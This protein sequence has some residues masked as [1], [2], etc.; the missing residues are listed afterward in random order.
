MTG[1]LNRRNFTL[2]E[3]L[4]TIAIIAILAAV[5]LPALN[6]ARAKR[7]AIR[8]TSNLKQMGTLVFLYAEANDGYGIPFQDSP[9]G[10]GFCVWPDFLMPY[11]KPG[12]EMKAGGYRIYVDSGTGKYIPRDIF[13]CP[14]VGNPVVDGRKE[15]IKH[16]GMNKY[17]SLTEPWQLPSR[18]ILHTK[19]PAA[20]SYIADVF[21]PE[22]YTSSGGRCFRYENV[23]E[24]PFLH[25]SR[26]NMVFVDGHCEA[27]R[28]QSI[29]PA[30][31]AGSNDFWGA[32]DTEN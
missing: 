15:E 23:Q 14:G 4:V 26:N 5:L 7:Q 12:V 24:M 10:I 1:C 9:A 11:L 30:Y 28:F 16:Y 17:P 21:H 3:L 29:R 27:R 6:S 25:L 13:A 8:C 20:R 19:R 2:I 18:R 32:S 31:S 22:N